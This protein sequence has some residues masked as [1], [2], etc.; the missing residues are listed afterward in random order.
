MKNQ[1][2]KLRVKCSFSPN[3]CPFELSLDILE[4]HE[5]ECLFNEINTRIT[6][7]VEDELK[8]DLTFLTRL[9]KHR[10]KYE[11]EVIRCS[12]SE[13]MKK[14]AVKLSKEALYLCGRVNFGLISAYIKTHLEPNQNKYW[15]CIAG[16][17]Y[18]CL[19]TAYHFFITI[20]ID[21]IYIIAFKTK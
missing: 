10:H 17:D 13:E 14:M 12:M 18:D 1:L 11:Y 19:L 6:R 8:L 9:R 20:K 5:K 21:S 4:D 3:G 16:T 2:N 7:R 15:H